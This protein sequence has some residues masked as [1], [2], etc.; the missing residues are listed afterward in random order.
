[1]LLSYIIGFALVFPFLG[2][3]F[4][5]LLPPLPLTN[6]VFI[7]EEIHVSPGLLIVEEGLFILLEIKEL[8]GF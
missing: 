4:L 8:L 6:E 7:L 5:S 3:D 1:L 2:V